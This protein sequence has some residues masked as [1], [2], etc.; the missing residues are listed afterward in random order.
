MWKNYL[1]I[2]AKE[3]EI[4]FIKQSSQRKHI[5]WKTT[6]EDYLK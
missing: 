3:G 2:L 6:N 1:E 4:S 5:P